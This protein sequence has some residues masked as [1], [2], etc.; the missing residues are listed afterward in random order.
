MNFKREKI[1]D[2][3]RKVEKEK[4]MREY[5]RDKMGII[6]MSEWPKMKRQNKR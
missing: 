1:K 6:D 4:E 2:E 3:K 5:E